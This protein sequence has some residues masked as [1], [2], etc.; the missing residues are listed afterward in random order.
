M[1]PLERGIVDVLKQHMPE[2]LA[3]SVRRRAQSTIGA[4]EGRLDVQ[5]IPRF[6]VELRAGLRLFANASNHGAICAAIEELAPTSQRLVL[7]KVD[8]QDEHDIARARSVARRL[9]TQLGASSFAAQR[10][11]TAVSELSRNVVAYASPGY[12]EML[13]TQGPPASITVVAVDKGRGI[14]QLDRILA[15]TYRSKTGLGKGLAGVKKLATRFDVV[16][17]AQGTRV[18]AIIS[19]V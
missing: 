19:L 15:G 18:E 5:H 17:G 13:P 14:E 1:N 10:A 4:D 2:I 8:L 12:I 3:S 7:E 16:T 11:A 6:L 9:S